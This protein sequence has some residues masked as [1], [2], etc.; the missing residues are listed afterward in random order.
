[1]TRKGTTAQPL[2]IHAN[3]KKNTLATQY[4][5]DFETLLFKICEC[6]GDLISDCGTFFFN[7]NLGEQ[8]TN[9]TDT[10]TQ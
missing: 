5:N 7:L 2:M 8:Q 4:T 10:T 1:M 3:G 6:T 9:F